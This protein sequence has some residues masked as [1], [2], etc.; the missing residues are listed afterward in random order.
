MLYSTLSVLRHRSYHSFGFDLGL[1]DQVIWNTTQGRILE[2][3]M[4]GAIAQPHVQMSDHFSPIYVLLAPFYAIYPHPESL[5]VLQTAALAL[6]VWPVYLLAKL[7]LPA[8]YPLLWVV[9]Y[10]LFVPLA[11]VNLYDFHE[12]AFSVAPLGFALYFL[13][14]GRAAWFIAFLVFTF[15]IK[16]ELAIVAVG[17]GAYALVGKRNWKVGLGVI[18][19][20]LA[21][22]GLVTGVIIPSLSGGRT[23]RYF[24]DRYGYLGDTP[25]AIIKT[26]ITDPL[27]IVR[28]LIVPKKVFFATAIF[29]P[30]LGLSWVAGWAVLMLLPPVTYL[31]LSNDVAQY[32]FTTQYSAVLISLVVGAAIIGMAKLPPGARKYFAASVLASSLLFSWA[33]GDQPYSRKFDPTIFETEQRYA[34]FVP[35]LGQIPADARVSAEDD[36]TSH[37]SE[38]RFIYSY[39][40]EGI[41]DADWVVLDYALL[42]HN[43]SAFESQVAAAE[44]RGYVVVATGEGL[45]LLRKS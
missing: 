42:N 44:A 17:F 31:L 14:R 36:L 19:G 30:V 27:R 8:G 1:Y 9:V 7:K 38:R 4:A 2:S 12:I 23:Y 20:S 22:F 28:A 29:G 15:L 40:F 11:Y 16:E 43:E 24:A 6:G 41:Q 25:L 37:L 3:T 10:V 45:A 32:S 39:D 34:A 21:V 33:F 18:A 13:E 26:A 35:Q 5:L